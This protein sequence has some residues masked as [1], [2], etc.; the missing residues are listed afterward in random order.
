MR[1]LFYFALFPQKERPTATHSLMAIWSVITTVP[2]LLI[3]PEEFRKNAAKS[4]WALLDD[5]KAASAQN[6]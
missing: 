3:S 4:G 6:K 2:L 1:L 5:P